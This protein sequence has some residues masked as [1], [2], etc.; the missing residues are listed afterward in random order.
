MKIETVFFSDGSIHAIKANNR[1]VL[2]FRPNASGEASLARCRQWRDV[3]DHA[4]DLA[5]EFAANIFRL[6]VLTIESLGIL[7]E[8]AQENFRRVRGW[9]NAAQV[10][11][12]IQGI[13]RSFLGG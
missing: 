2:V 11:D 1:E 10:S 6:I 9:E 5:D 13:E 8:H 4:T 12:R 3:E 7:K